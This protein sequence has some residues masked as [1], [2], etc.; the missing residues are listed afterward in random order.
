MVE[1]LKR[2]SEQGEVNMLEFYQEFTLDVICKIAL[3]QKDVEMFKNPLIDLCRQVFSAPQSYMFTNTVIFMPFIKKP[4][5]FLLG[6]LARYRK[7][8]YVK[9]M[10]DVGLEVEQRKNARE[11]GAS[12]SGDF[13]DIFLDAEVESNDLEESKVG[14]HHVSR[15]LLFDEIVSLCLVMLLGGFETTANSLSY[16]THFLANHPEVQ[17]K[18][19]EEVQAIFP[20][21]TINY[22]DLSELKYTEAAI[23]E[24]LRHYPLGSVGV[25]RECQK[26]TTIGGMQLEVGDN[27][28]TDTWSLHKD[29]TIWGED[30]EEFRPERWLEDS[31][32]PRV[33]FQGFGEG[34]RMCI[35]IRL[36]FMEEKTAIAHLL[37]NFRIKKS[38]NT[39]P[40]KL[41]G[42]ITVAPEKVN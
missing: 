7:H 41:V 18:I 37:K 33:A 24:S 20:N 1:E 30:A 31:S 21:E 26:R 2:R 19:Y 17:E 27:I 32:R 11:A 8:P 36:A 39:N 13:I 4:L 35:G 5:L 3:G 6:K 15:K 12:S 25:T 34:P 23:K 22:E 28:L 10:R 38:A 16:L 40:I 42:T 9:L 14:H 29:K